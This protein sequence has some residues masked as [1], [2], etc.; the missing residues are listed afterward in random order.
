MRHHSIQRESP[1]ATAD[2][3]GRLVSPH[4]G[5][6]MPR[7]W[8]SDPSKWEGHG[9]H[10]VVVHVDSAVG[11]K[12]I[13]TTLTLKQFTNAEPG[14]L[15]LDVDVAGAANPNG[16]EDGRYSTTIELDHLALLTIAE[17]FRRL[18]PL[19]RAHGLIPETIE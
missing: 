15:W 14:E 10:D 18:V 5:V 16:G 13:A 2:P 12:R 4:T 6:E 3:V 17:A 11:R 19:A 9:S 1:A 8:H 7:G